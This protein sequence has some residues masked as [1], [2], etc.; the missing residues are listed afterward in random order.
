MLLLYIKL[1]LKKK[2][3]SETSLPA[4]FS[5]LCSINWPNFIV[6]LSLLFEIS[7]K[8]FIVI[9]CVSDCDVTKLEIYLGFLI[10]LFFYMFCEK[11]VLRNF[12]K[13]TGKHLCQDLFFNKVAGLRPVTL[14]KKETLTQVFSCEFCE[15]SKSTFSHRTPLVSTSTSH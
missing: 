5:A 13:F 14:L 3:G 9:V 12:T 2:K 10:K 4:S 8:M 11:D 6:L 15:I 7:G 1:F